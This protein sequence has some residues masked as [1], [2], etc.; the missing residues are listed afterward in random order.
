DYKLGDIPE[1]VKWGV[2]GAAKRG[3]DFV[4]V[5]GAGDAAR[6]ALEAAVEGRGMFELSQSAHQVNFLMTRSLCVYYQISHYE[7]ALELAGKLIKGVL[8][9]QKGF[10]P[11]GRW[12]LRH[13]HTAAASLLAI[14]EY[15]LILEDREQIEFVNRCYLFGKASGDDVTGHFPEHV[16]GTGDYLERRLCETCEVADMICLAIKLTQA[17]AGDYWSDVERWVRNQFVE[18]QLT[19]E[20]LTTL[21][22][23]L[24]EGKQPVAPQ[25][26]DWMQTII[27]DGNRQRARA[28]ATELRIRGT[29]VPFDP[30]LKKD[31]DKSNDTVPEWASLDM[32]RAV[33]C[34]SG[35]ALPNDWGA[36]SMHGCCTGNA[37]RTIY[38]IWDCIVTREDGIVKVNLLM[39]RASQW[40]DVDSY[41]PYQGRVVLKIKDAATAAVRI[42][43]WTDRENVACTVGGAEHGYEWSGNYILID[44]LTSGDVVDIRFPMVTQTSFR[45]IAAD[46]T[47]KLTVKGYTVIDIEPKGEI[48]PL[49]NRNACQGDTAPMKK[50]TQVVSNRRII[51]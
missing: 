45:V 10:E 1:T 48:C 23:N 7:P 36:M 6:A 8:E 49:Y 4:T 30:P 24:R 22:T 5:Q 51:W 16:P 3:V 47:Y 43:E 15:A 14:L 35:W 26:I 21:L 44:G 39:N 32:E 28:E 50:V 29:M 37:S 9:Q 33:G 38:W 11:D 17:G 20:K 46:T 18:N 25:K 12:L 27:D 41:L 2:R 40:L 42:P 13:F 31:A 19:S 34:F